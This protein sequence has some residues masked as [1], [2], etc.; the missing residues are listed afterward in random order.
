MINAHYKKYFYFI[1]TGTSLFRN[2]LVPAVAFSAIHLS[3]QES[4]APTTPAPQTLTPVVVTGE[5]NTPPTPSP[6]PAVAPAPDPA[7]TPQ[8]S[9]EPPLVIDDLDPQ[10][11]T[12]VLIQRASSTLDVLTNQFMEDRDIRRIPDILGTI[13]NVAVNDL[14]E[15]ANVPTFTV[16][17]SA[18]D[19]NIDAFGGTPFVAYYVDD[20]PALS[21]YG[22]SLPIFNLNS[23]KFYKGPHGTQFGAPGSAGVLRL[24]SI[25]PGNEFQGSGGY[26]YGSYNRHQL[27]GSV[28]APIINDVLAI[29]FSGLYET[30]DGY[31]HNAVLN[32]PYGGI[33]E[34]AGRMQL[35]WTPSS[36]LEVLFTV[37]VGNQDNG[38]PNFTSNNG[39]DL[40][41]VYQGIDGFQK[42]DSNVEALRV[43]SKGDGL[44][45]V[46]S[47][48][49]QSNIS[50]IYYDFGTFFGANPYTLDTAYGT[51]D[52]NEEAY[53][54][55]FRV[56]SDDENSP[57]Q[58]TGGV[59]FG[60]RDNKTTGEMIYDNLLGVFNSF[61]RFPNNAK[62]DTYAVFGQTAYTFDDRLE[63]SAGLRLETVKSTRNSAMI[64]PLF[65]FGGDSINSGKKT[66]SAASPMA[67]ISWKWNDDQRTYFRYSTGFQPGDIASASHIVA[68]AER[69]YEEQTSYNFE[70]GHKASFFDDRFTVNPVLFYTH[71]DNYQAFVDMGTLGLPLTAVFNAESAHAM[72]AELQIGAEPVDGLRFASN[73]GVQ[74]AKYD[75]FSFGGGSYNGFDI[76]NIPAYSLRNNVSYRQPLGGGFIMGMLECNVTGNYEFDQKNT[77]S[78][79]AYTLFNARLGYEWGQSGAYLFGA[80]LLDEAYLP[81]GY[82][83]APAGTFRGTPGAP[84]TFGFEIRTKF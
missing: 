71:Y 42:F 29:G 41:T 21:V 78:Q 52:I 39:G 69:E 25:L 38:G 7:P 4:A 9:P 2:V 45:F 48:S 60:T 47:T 67:G 43:T 3:A 59:F 19:M 31:V 56:E 58:W 57:L 13:S 81:N 33:E 22:R 35:V 40:F 46:S 53:T 79:D 63:I 77:G 61:S 83:D 49:R 24:D 6:R 20:I 10:V 76:P 32:R 72:G 82:A 62:Q 27:D 23:A 75:E 15:I 11:N 84:Q 36:D 1:Q 30:R 17:G 8:L 50:N 80:N 65:F 37:G 44:R 12:Q 51:Y 70:L 34:A 68:G 64:D 28:S 66:T 18:E 55:E 16:R 26:T 5:T 14:T 73:L 74:E 54:Q